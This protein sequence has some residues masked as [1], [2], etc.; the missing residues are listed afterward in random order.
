[1]RKLSHFGQKKLHERM[2]SFRRFCF[3]TNNFQVFAIMS[4]IKAFF[5]DDNE[6]VMRRSFGS[7]KIV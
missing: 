2:R 3:N 7:I 6:V 5:T 4:I 1:M